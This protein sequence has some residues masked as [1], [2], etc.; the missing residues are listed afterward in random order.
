MYSMEAVDT[1]IVNIHYSHIQTFHLVFIYSVES[2]TFA[3]VIIHYSS[4]MSC[5]DLVLE[6]LNSALSQ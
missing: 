3:I 6:A 5:Q 4:E 2:P 1:S